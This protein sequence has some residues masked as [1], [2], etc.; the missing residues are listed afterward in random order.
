M[1]T[2]EQK[3]Q[4]ILTVAKAFYDRGVCVQYDQRSMDRKLQLTP[5]RRKYLPPE[6][7]SSQYVHFLDCSGYTSAVYLTAFGYE[8]PSDL[9]WLMIDQMEAQVFY[10]ELTH[11]ETLEQ[12]NAVKA[13]VLQIL[14]PGDLI[15]YDRGEGSGHIM[16][17]LGDDTY[18]DCAVPFG[19]K[20]SYNFAEKKNQLYCQGIWKKPM[21]EFLLPDDEQELRTGRRSL[22]NGNTRRFAIH[23][24]LDVLGE[25]PEQTQI[26]M[27]QAKDLWCAVE[28]SASGCLQAYPGE[29][30]RYTVIVRNLGET[31]RVV[32]VTFAAPAGCKFCGEGAVSQAVKAGQEIRVPFEVVVDTDNTNACLDGPVVTVN[33]LLIYTHPVLLGR[34]MDVKDVAEAVKKEMQTGA[35]ALAAASKAYGAAGISLNPKEKPYTWT[36][37]CYHDSPA[38]HVLSRRPQKPFADLAVY[39]AFGGVGVITSDMTAV[40]GVRMTHITRADLLPGDLI[41]CFDDPLGNSAYSAFFDGENLMGRFT[42]EDEN[43]TICGDE[44]DRFIDS[45]F[46]QFAFLVLRPAQGKK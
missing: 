12:I 40:Q 26:R 4:A 22:F 17:Y 8:L 43:R 18:T 24:P 30:L 23:R 36:H 19:E 20:N 35:T 13:Q 14:E 44:L 32:D 29:P 6:A 46:G 7:S 33:R 37:F 11:Q 21:R 39:S 42:A 41:L 1:A 31:D 15:T 27:N 5:R 10:Y 25:I 38:G 28:S 16:L 3:Q 45:L 9:T 2:K 34:K